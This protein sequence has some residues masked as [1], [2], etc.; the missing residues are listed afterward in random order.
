MNWIASHR[1]VGEGA[2]FGNCR[3]NHLLFADELVLH[4]WIFSTALAQPAQKLEVG[5][6]FDFRQ[7]TLFC[8]EKHHSKHK[9]TIGP[10]APHGYAYVNRVFSTHQID[11]LLRVTKQERKSA[12]KIEVFCLSRSPRQCILHVSENTLQQVQTF[13]YL[14]VVFASDGS[15]NKG[16]DTRISKA[17][18]VLCR[19][20]SNQ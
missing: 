12:L 20:G 18:A 3:M 15:R 11:F 4:A 1:R 14:G 17:N 5:K 7:I 2:T 8:L 19:G 13:K 6:I 10:C 16:I 9:M